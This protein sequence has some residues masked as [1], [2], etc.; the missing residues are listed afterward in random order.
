MAEA[1]FPW[2]EAMAFGFGHLRLGPDAF[3][4]MTLKELSAAASA[5]GRQTNDPISRERF[6]AL[7]A[8]YPDKGDGNGD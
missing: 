4:R 1:R 7:Q 3:W 2:H 8:A 5:H 6:A